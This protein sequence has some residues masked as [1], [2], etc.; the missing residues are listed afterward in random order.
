MSKK[1]LSEAPERSPRLRPA[2]PLEVVFRRLVLA[3]R[4]DLL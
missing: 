4:F 3:S 1:Q 2:R